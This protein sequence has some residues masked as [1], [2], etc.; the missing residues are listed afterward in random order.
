MSKLATCPKHYILLPMNTDCWMCVETQ[1]DAH[2]PRIYRN[3]YGTLMLFSV[4]N[5]ETPTPEQMT[6]KA[7]KT[8]APIDNSEAAASAPEQCA[9]ND[10]M[11]RGP[12]QIGTGL[13]EVHS[14]IRPV[15]VLHREMRLHLDPSEPQTDQQ[16]AAERQLKIAT[17]VLGAILTGDSRGAVID[18]EAKRR[19]VNVALDW[20]DE[21]LQSWQSRGVPIHDFQHRD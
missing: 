16:Q 1:E 2:P 18:K 21:L 6:M 14:G 15:P 3:H 5:V 8:V 20:A 17:H 13:C 7:E 12:V 4:A 9:F 10:W 19:W 11:C